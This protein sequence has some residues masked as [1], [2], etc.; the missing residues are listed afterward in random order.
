MDGKGDVDAVGGLTE[1]IDG[2]IRL[3]FG[4]IDWMIIVVIGSSRVR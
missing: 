1:G 4:R 3:R 2:L